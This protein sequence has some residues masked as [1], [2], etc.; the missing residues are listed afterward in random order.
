MYTADGRTCKLIT[1]PIE[2]IN[3]SDFQNGV[4]FISIQLENSMSYYD[5]IIVKK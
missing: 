4:Y 3:V 1:G 2:K 5:K